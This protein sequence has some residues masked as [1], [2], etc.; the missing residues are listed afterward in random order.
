LQRLNALQAANQQFSERFLRF[1]SVLV[2]LADGR[3]IDG[4]EAMPLIGFFR[5]LS[6]LF[7]SDVARTSNPAAKPSVSLPQ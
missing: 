1:R 4:A 7:E 2:A 6:D 5:V 3:R